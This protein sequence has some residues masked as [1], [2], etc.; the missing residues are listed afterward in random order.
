M[1]RILSDWLLARNLIDI[2]YLL[3]LSIHWCLSLIH[4]LTLH[5]DLPLNHGLVGRLWLLIDTHILSKLRLSILLA[6]WH[7]SWLPILVH[8]L[9]VGRVGT[10]IHWLCLAYLLCIWLILSVASK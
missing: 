3:T 5:W 8:R 9:V 10:L 2:D 1:I 6:L 7:V 4:N